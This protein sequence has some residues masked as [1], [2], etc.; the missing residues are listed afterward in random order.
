[1]R[2]FK[3]RFEAVLQLDAIARELIPTTHHRP[4]EALLGVGH[5]A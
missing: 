2:F 1:M 5:E 4:P 3:E